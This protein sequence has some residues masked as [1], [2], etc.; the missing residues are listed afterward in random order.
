MRKIGLRLKALNIIDNIVDQLNGLVADIITTGLYLIIGVRII[1]SLINISRLI[2][3]P[4]IDKPNPTLHGI[5]ILLCLLA[6][7]IS[8][9]GKYY[10]K[11]SR[12][13]AQYVLIV[14]GISMFSLN[15][16]AETFNN[17]FIKI[18]SNI[19]NVDV[20]PSELLIGNIRVVTLIIPIAIIIPMF[21]LS[22]DV[23]KDKKGKA[24]LRE[25][26]TQILL[27]TVHKMTDSTID[28]EIC[29]DLKT[30]LPCVVPE[31]TWYEHAWIQG[32]TGSGKTQTFIL[33]FIEQL[34]KKKS[35]LH[36]QLKCITHECLEKGIARIKIPISN[37]WFNEEFE[38]ELVEPVEGR[39]K[40]FYEHFKDYTIGIIEK[41]EI[42]YEQ[43]FISTN[44]FELEAQ[45]SGD[46][47]Y[48]IEIKTYK[49]N[50]IIDENTFEIKKNKEDNYMDTGTI[51][52]KSR[53]KETGEENTV[54]NE[55]K[56]T[57]EYKIDEKI[58]I[59]EIQIDSTDE[60]NNHTV[61]AYLKGS[62]RLVPRNLGITVIAPDG[63]LVATTVDIA[64]KYGIKVHKIDPYMDEIKKGGI[65]KFNPLKGDS[66]EKIGDIVASILV[67]MDLG[68]QSKTNPYFTNASV[69]AI[70]N[71]VILLK[72]TYPE[73]YNR[74]PTLTDV[75][76]CLNNFKEVEEPV[77]YLE[78]NLTLMRRWKSVVDYFKTSFFDP[79]TGS[80]GKQ[81]TTSSIGSQKRKTQEAI[82]GII[83]QL[84]NLLSREE[85]KY[86]LCNEE[87]SIDLADAL[88]KGE[89]I[90]ISTRQ[91][92]LGARLG[93]AFALFFILSLQ[94]E[95][96]SRYA[97][98]ENP[99]IPHFLIIDE[100]PMYCNE[101]TETF[102]SFARKYK[103]SVTIAIQNMGQLRKISD[104]FGETI[105]T[106]TTTKL[107]LP[108]ANLQDRKYWSDFFGSTNE[109]QLMTGVATSSI[110]A[111]NPSYSEQVRA[112]VT[113]TRNISE[114]EVDNL[115]FQQLYYSYSNK[116][117]RKVVGKGTTEFIKLKQEPYMK[118][119]FDFEPYCITEEE[120][121]I[122]IELEKIEKNKLKEKEN[123]NT[124]Q[125]Q[126]RIKS[127]L[128]RD[129][130]DIKEDIKEDVKEDTKETEYV[131]IEELPSNK[132]SDI[133]F[134]SIDCCNTT[135]KGE[136]KNIVENEPK[137]NIS[138]FQDT[139]IEE[140]IEKEIEFYL[141]EDN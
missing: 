10:K 54:F 119:T 13:I 67:S 116:K 55:E 44:T 105:F 46:Y 139:E 106:N 73:L 121:R 133:V 35:Y 14:T 45:K 94:N 48:I 3:N 50:M 124:L 56:N 30:G 97:E 69:R 60:N 53:I 49:N 112:N 64:K 9:L 37:K 72:I 1:L 110:F 127:S 33:P 84:D 130:E 65:A 19:N 88:R 39:E 2:E 137:N 135:N 25:Y 59:I 85:I 21:I 89:C 107:L 101:S 129:E 109:I 66:P 5:F 113:E 63:E 57:V 81:I 16:L 6:F 115:N 26:E 70:R 80:D 74:E 40:E 20:I 17:I 34:L 71:L 123:L 79:P 108:K 42:V 8:L 32:G 122:K 100:F 31:K 24:K 12:R 82:S 61:K 87:E 128:Y 134:D 29:K 78:K 120:Y 23:L 83:N 43:D 136:E 68:S 4:I 131:L 95:V 38:L 11:P 15:Y 102:F 91:G 96:L 27:P 90:A 125:K 141:Y 7:Y 18:L 111:D 140:E 93:R 52:F 126:E 47:I 99:E 118:K 104:E 86:I 117:G 77:N 28:I 114:E 132:I 58:D 22:L 62:G 92:H 98:N 75:L 41:E 51:I 103:C 36:Y 138:Q 76:S